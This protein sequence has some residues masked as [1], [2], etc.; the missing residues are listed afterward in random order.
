MARLV[1]DQRLRSTPEVFFASVEQ[2]QTHTIVWDIPSTSGCSILVKEMQ[3]S[4][5]SA[6]PVVCPIGEEVKLLSI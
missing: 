4:Y 2:A 1:K 6:A 3:H 5:Y